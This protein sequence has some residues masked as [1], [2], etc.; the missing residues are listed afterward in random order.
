MALQ[1]PHPS[2]DRDQDAR[3]QEHPRRRVSTTLDHFTRFRDLT[4]GG[5]PLVDS[6]PPYCSAFR[7]STSWP[8]SFRACR[9][10][11]PVI[12]ASSLSHP[13]VRPRVIAADLGALWASFPLR[14]GA[15]V[16]AELIEEWTGVLQVP[17]PERGLRRSDQ[18]RVKDEAT[19]QDNQDEDQPYHPRPLLLCWLALDR[20]QTSARGHIGETVR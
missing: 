6:T 18:H 20:T 2:C 12:I 3:D 15:N 5:P 13:A 19:E 16:G 14:R 9:I 11:A 8:R 4:P 1:K 17:R 7:M 10:C